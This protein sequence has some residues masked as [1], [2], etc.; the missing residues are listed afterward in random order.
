MKNHAHSKIGEY[1]VK[2][3]PIEG[4]KTKDGKIIPPHMKKV[5]FKWK[6]YN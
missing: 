3:K 1:G 5:V 6:K 4:H 2:W